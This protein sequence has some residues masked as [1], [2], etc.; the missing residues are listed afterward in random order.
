ME[1]REEGRKEDGCM[2]LRTI[3]WLVHLTSSSRMAQEKRGAFA[4]QKLPT[5]SFMHLFAENWLLSFDIL[6]R[7]KC[8][9]YTGNF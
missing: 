1:E 3:N 6:V 7:N 9:R 5:E 2:T 8:P 4:W